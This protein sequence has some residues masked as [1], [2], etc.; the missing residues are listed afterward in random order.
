MLLATK[1]RR[2]RRRRR[3]RQSRLLYLCLGAP[4]EEEACGG[5][6]HGR[7]RG[8]EVPHAC[9]RRRRSLFCFA[10]GLPSCS[11]W[12]VG[13]AGARKGERGARRPV[14]A[15][16][17]GWCGYGW[18][19]HGALD[20]RRGAGHLWVGGVGG[21]EFEL[22]GPSKP[23]GRG[24]W[25]RGPPVAPRQ[26]PS[27]KYLLGQGVGKAATSCVGRMW[28]CPA[29]GHE[30]GRGRQ[31]PHA[32]AVCSAAAPW[33]APPPQR[34]RAGPAGADACPLHEATA[35]AGS[36]GGK[37]TRERARRV[38]VAAH[39]RATN[40]GP[41]PPP[42]PVLWRGPS[43]GLWAS[44]CC[45][46]FLLWWWAWH[47]GTFPTTTSRGRSTSLVGQRAHW[48]VGGEGGGK[49]GRLS[50]ER[51]IRTPSATHQQRR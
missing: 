17:C 8:A 46:V 18:V 15:C 11:S 1:R 34:H 39:T 33:T 41:P 16:G 24:M 6:D 14:C 12:W 38:A 13:S 5:R 42:P 25:G 7:C 36:E 47:Q 48:W 4:E 50:A 37:R 31:Q 27:V 9:M 30:E 44:V 45:L 19:G 2:R 28:P 49:G 32:Q 21:P 26:G 35:G 51:Y 10:L 23:I 20:F 43:T 22:D 40:V 3:R 29:H